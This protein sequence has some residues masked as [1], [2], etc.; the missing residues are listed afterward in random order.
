MNII[1]E[2]RMNVKIS[3]QAAEIEF[4][5]KELQ[6]AHDKIRDLYETISDREQ[7]LRKYRFNDPEF[8]KAAQSIFGPVFESMDKR[9]LAHEAATNRK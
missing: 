2:F 5:K 4:L 6:F 8:K 7:E 1:E 9:A 3:D